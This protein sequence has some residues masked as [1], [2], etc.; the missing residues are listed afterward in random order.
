MSIG[1]HNWYVLTFPDQ[2]TWVY[3]FNTGEWHERESLGFARWNVDG[4][5]RAYNKDFAFYGNKVGVIDED[6]HDEWG[7][8][9]RGRW[10]YPAVYGEGRR[11][12][13]RRFEIRCEVGVGNSDVVEPK[14]TLEISDDGGK[15]WTAL[16]TRSLG[17]VG[18]YKKRLIWTR[19]GSAGDRVYRAS[20]AD[21]ARLHIW[22][23]ELL[24][25][26]GRLLGAA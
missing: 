6:D 16:P 15:T 18:E 12:F 5:L 19:L 8:E 3:D 13:H 26:G 24:V 1:G 11:A 23:S 14:L 25:E 9:I 17:K 4:Y 2:G 10:T 20:M 22:R 21:P 7:T